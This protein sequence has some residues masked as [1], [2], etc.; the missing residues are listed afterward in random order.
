MVRK[1]KVAAFRDAGKECSRIL[2][3]AMDM[4]AS[5]PRPVVPVVWALTL[6][7]SHPAAD[8]KIKI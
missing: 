8:K 4:A 5:G 7:A 6:Q 1:R 3:F 2:E